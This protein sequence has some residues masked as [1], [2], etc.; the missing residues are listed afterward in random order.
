MKRFILFACLLFFCTAAEART[1]T[2]VDETD[3][4][5]VML[6]LGF[7]CEALDDSFSFQA[8]EMVHLTEH[9]QYCEEA[10]ENTPDYKYGRLMC[11]YVEIQWDLMNRHLMAVDR[12]RELMCE[13]GERK[14][15]Q[16]EI[17]F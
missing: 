13:D 15:P 16:Y 7:P 5:L 8:Y 6:Y 1:D 4:G 11:V 2:P 12:A 14:N 10:R 17:E 9:M 3:P